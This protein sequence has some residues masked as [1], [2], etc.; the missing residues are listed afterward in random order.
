MKI[1]F[2]GCSW[3]EG[4]ELQDKKKERYSRVV[5]DRL[6]AEESNFGRSGGSNDRIVRRLLIHK[7]IEDYDLAVIQMTL[8]ARTEYWDNEWRFINPKH[9]Y[10]KWLFGKEGKID[11]LGSKF[12]EHSDFWKYY[13]TDITNEK[14]FD[15]KEEVHYKTIRDHCKCRG[16]PLILCTINRWTSLD[17]DI[18][19]DS[20]TLNKHR[21]GHPTRE[22]HEFLAGEILKLL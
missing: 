11:T 3:T 7:K 15:V 8:P 12:K 20:A 6:N 2:D 1:Y 13:Y 10:S 4:A 21:Y 18:H 16:I 14:Y 9:N 19:M 17:F 5:C 22:G